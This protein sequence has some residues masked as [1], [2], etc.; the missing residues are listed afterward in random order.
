MIHGILNNTLL[1]AIVTLLYLECESFLLSV[2]TFKSAADK[3]FPSCLYSPALHSLV[4]GNFFSVV[5]FC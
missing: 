2:S 1:L 4:S 3:T 5:Y